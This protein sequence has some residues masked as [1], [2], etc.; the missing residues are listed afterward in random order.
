MVIGTFVLLAATLH[1]LPDYTGYSGAPGTD[2]TCASTCHGPSTGTI[3]AVGFPTVYELDQSYVVSV[4]H[5]DGSSVSN[6]NVSVR[7]GTTSQTAGH[8]TATDTPSRPAPASSRSRAAASGW[9][10]SWF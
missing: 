1:A 5:R 9:C 7:M 3:A 2:G 4:V 10:T 6:F 8:L